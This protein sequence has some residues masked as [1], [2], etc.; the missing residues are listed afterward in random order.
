MKIV[1]YHINLQLTKAALSSIE[2][3]LSLDSP[4]RTRNMGEFLLKT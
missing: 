3:H 4:G 2:D 1:N